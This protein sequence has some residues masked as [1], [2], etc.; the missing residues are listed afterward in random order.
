MYLRRSFVCRSSKI[1]FTSFLSFV[2]N[3]YIL[4]FSNTLDFQ[5]ERNDM[6]IHWFSNNLTN[7][8]FFH[9]SEYRFITLKNADI[10]CEDE[11][12]MMTSFERMTFVDVLCQSKQETDAEVMTRYAIVTVLSTRLN[13]DVLCTRRDFRSTYSLISSFVMTWNAFEY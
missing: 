9:K 7:S 4:T 5:S 8:S 2:F 3:E 11:L 1:W 12:W 10:V 6:R 13:H